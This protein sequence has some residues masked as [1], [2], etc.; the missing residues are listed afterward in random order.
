MLVVCYCLIALR[1][2]YQY[3]ILTSNNQ[4]LSASS[5][6]TGVIPTN[7][8]DK[9]L[10]PSTQPEDSTSDEGRGGA[11]TPPPSEDNNGG[12]FSRENSDGLNVQTSSSTAADGAAGAGG[13]GSAL[14]LLLGIADDATN[15]ASGFTLPPT[16]NIEKERRELLDPTTLPTSMTNF[17]EDADRY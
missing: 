9:E 12:G 15:A 10:M 17:L 13:E 4:Y 14:E 11:S 1:F 5:T 16:P 3:H 8:Q 6:T 2:Q 7:V